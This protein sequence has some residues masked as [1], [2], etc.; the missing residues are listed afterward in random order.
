MA[1]PCKK[2]T[3]LFSRY[4]CLKWFQ[5]HR[6]PFYN[7]YGVEAVVPICHNAYEAALGPIYK[8]SYAGGI[9]LVVWSYS[10]E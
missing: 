3:A 5:A 2:F 1:N 7:Y 4:F 6:C 10:E 9:E 8:C